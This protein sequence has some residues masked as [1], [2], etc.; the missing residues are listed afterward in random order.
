LGGGGGGGGGGGQGF[1]ENSYGPLRRLKPCLEKEKTT[2]KPYQEEIP[3]EEYSS[4]RT[5]GRI[6]GKV[7]AQGKGG[8]MGIEMRRDV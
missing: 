5:D 6:K 2:N 3:N 4:V 7:L 1:Y 8:I